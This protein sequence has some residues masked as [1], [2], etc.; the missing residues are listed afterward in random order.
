[1]N[2]DQQDS[3]DVFSTESAER[4]E[5]AGSVWRT[6]NIR[7]L[8]AVAIALALATTASW[9]GWKAS[10]ADAM[11]ADASPPPIVTGTAIFRSLP[12]GASISVD[13]TTYGTTPARVTLPAGS[14]TVEIS[15]GSLSRTIPV[16]V[17]AG[18]V[19]THYFELATEA[20]VT[21]RLEVSSSVAGSTVSLDGVSRGVTP[22]VLSDVAPGQHTIAVSSGA[23]TWRRSVTVTGGA[24]SSIFVSTVAQPSAAGGWLAVDSPI[25]LEIWDGDAL[26]GSTRTERLML[27]VGSH[28]LVLSNDDL[29]YSS[30]QT[31]QIT[32]GNTA[33]LTVTPGRGRLAVNAVPWA[34]VFIDGVS[35]GIT[36]LGELSVRVGSHDV[37]F[38]HPQLGERRQNVVVKSKSPTLIGVDLRK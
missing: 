1:M 9:F 12:D 6:L 34:E 37:V 10:Q 20:P 38:R 19:A 28:R 31:V 24:T 29:E 26:V 32:A 2:A 17:E 16:T 8:A 36:P 35:A 11:T 33:Q 30:T 13:G 21:G 25:E 3:L 5:S 18:T 27:P 14:H 22:L 7:I 15:R 23:T 4:T